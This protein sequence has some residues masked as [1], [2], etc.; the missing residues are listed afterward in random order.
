M[1]FSHFSCTLITYYDVMQLLLTNLF[2]TALN[3]AACES[4]ISYA[5]NYY[6]HSP[7]NLEVVLLSA[8]YL[9]LFVVLRLYSLTHC[10]HQLT[11]IEI[12]YLIHNLQ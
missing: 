2:L 9:I 5:C 3:S 7:T 10:Y 4:D 8:L 12:Y 6:F 1:S 11:E